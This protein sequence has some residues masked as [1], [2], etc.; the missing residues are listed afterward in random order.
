MIAAA[1]L[2]T[3][4]STCAPTVSPDTMRAIIAVESGRNELAVHDNTLGR[5]YAAHDRASAARLVH[6]LLARGDSVDVGIAQINS[7]NFTAYHVTPEQML[8]PCANLRVSSSILAGAYNRAV[9]RFPEPREAL[10]HA[11]MAYN[12]GS[13]FAGEPYVRAVV[14]AAFA[15]PI[16]PTISLLTRLPPIMPPASTVAS[17][18]LPRSPSSPPKP[19]TA[20][21]DAAFAA[22]GSGIPHTLE[23]QIQHPELP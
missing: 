4:L 11:I 10:R 15:Q 13:L 9:N 12:T 8:E 21:P 17:Q 22:I 2:V 18:A 19:S 16:V 23:M 14:N 7:G 6:A 3:Y 20:S 1:A 5:S